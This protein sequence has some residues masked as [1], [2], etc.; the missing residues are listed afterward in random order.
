MTDPYLPGSVVRLRDGS[1]ARIVSNSPTDVPYTI[2]GLLLERNSRCM[3]WTPDGAAYQDGTESCYDIISVIS[4]P[5]H[6]LTLT[7]VEVDEVVR[8]I[9]VLR[10]KIPQIRWHE[11]SKEWQSL[12]RLLGR[13]EEPPPYGRCPH[14][15]LPGECRER[16]PDGNDCCGNGHVYP[17]SSAVMDQKDSRS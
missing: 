4:S 10:S 16:R 8:C 17:S 12:L 7:P 5:P 14:C 3:N 1:T 13:E 2:T 11:V 15:G 6:G 9:S